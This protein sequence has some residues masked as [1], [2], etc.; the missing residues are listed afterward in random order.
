[1]ANPASVARSNQPS[2]PA[3]MPTRGQASA[4]APMP[5]RDRAQS[6]VPEPIRAIAA[7]APLNPSGVPAPATRPEPPAAIAAIAAP[8]PLIKPAPAT[9]APVAQWQNLLCFKTL[10][11]VIEAVKARAQPELQFTWSRTGNE[12]KIAIASFADLSTLSSTVFEGFIEDFDARAELVAAIEKLPEAI[13]SAVLSI[14]N[15]VAEETVSDAKNNKDTAMQ[16]E[17][18]WLAFPPKTE[19]PHP[20]KLAITVAIALPP[21]DTKPSLYPW[22]RILVQFGAVQRD[23]P[24]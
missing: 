10:D 14:I 7:P 13:S 22:N 12:P 1:M 23:F 20:P 19:P 16:L 18:L 4:P 3:P 24:F 17:G 6:S 9:I 8:A 5:T 2:A 21:S 15:Q 11:Q